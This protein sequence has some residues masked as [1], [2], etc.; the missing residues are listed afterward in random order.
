MATRGFSAT[1]ELILLAVL[2]TL[3]C[4]SQQRYHHTALCLW[5]V[6]TAMSQAMG[7]INNHGTVPLLFQSLVMFEHL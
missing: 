4:M 7:S 3:A 5:D 2:A 6:S 1:V